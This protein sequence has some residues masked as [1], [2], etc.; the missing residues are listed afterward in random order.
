MLITPDMRKQSSRLGCRRR[1]AGPSP[2][3][4]SHHPAIPHQFDQAR[5]LLQKALQ[6]DPQNAQAWLILAT[7]DMVQG[8]Y[9]APIGTAPGSRRTR[10]PRL[11]W[12]ASEPAFLHR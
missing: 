6:S 7:L 5:A 8:D 11:A 12:P 10:A 2:G 9:Q 3:H 1:G 4:S